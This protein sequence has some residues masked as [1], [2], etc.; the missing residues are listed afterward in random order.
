MC[1]SHLFRPAPR[2]L[3]IRSGHVSGLIPPWMQ[4]SVAFVA[5]TKYGAPALRRV[6]SHGYFISLQSGTQNLGCWRKMTALAWAAGYFYN[7][8]ILGPSLAHSRVKRLSPRAAREVGTFTL[9]TKGENP[10]QLSGKYVA[11]WEK[12]R[13]GWKLS[14][15]YLEFRAIT[16]PGAA[17]RVLSS[18]SPLLRA[19]ARFSHY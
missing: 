11:V 7:G 14:N 19:A 17:K 2:R 12:V 18:F 3:M 15:E 1:T 16:E 5:D 8:R 6:E 4:T 9:N 13:G 10:Q